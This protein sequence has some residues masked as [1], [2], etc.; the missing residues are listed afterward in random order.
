MNKQPIMYPYC[1]IAYKTKHSIGWKLAIMD[2]DKEYV[3]EKCIEYNWFDYIV[4]SAGKCAYHIKDNLEYFPRPYMVHLLSHWI[5]WQDLDRWFVKED[6]II[7]YPLKDCEIT[8]K[9][10]FSYDFETDN[11]WN[12]IEDF[13]DKEPVFISVEVGFETN[14]QKTETIVEISALYSEFEK[15][16][17]NL[18][19]KHFGVCH[20][21]EFTDYKL[22]AWEKDNQ[23]RFMIQDYHESSDSEYAPIVFDVLVNK[24]IFYKYFEEFYNSLK[25]ESQKMLQ[26]TIETVYNKL[27]NIKRQTGITILG[28]I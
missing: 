27:K 23:M 5:Y 24:D 18:K 13:D 10:Q 28:N 3:N 19:T 4:F 21:E 20:I 12:D 6:E 11:C 17:A 14:T 26:E 15:F 8:D 7:P 22:L 1:E 25:F 9:I 2:G 16:L